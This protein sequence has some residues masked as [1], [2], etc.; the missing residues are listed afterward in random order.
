MKACLMIGAI[1]MAAIVTGSTVAG[2]LPDSGSDQSERF[3]PQLHFTPGKNW[4]NDPNGMI[5]YQGEYHLFFQYNPQGRR[6][7]HMSWGH[8]VSPDL[9]HWTELPLAIPEDD[10][11]MIFSGSVVVDK[12]NSSGFGAGGE[13][14]MVA[15]YT[16][17]AQPPG[18][19]QSQHLA[20]SLDHGRSWQKYAGNPILDLHLEDFRDPKVFWYE[21]KKTWIMLVS[22]AAARKIS[23]YQSSDLRNWTHIS[24]FGPAGATDGFW[25]C[26]DLFPLPV[27]GSPGKVKWVLKVDSQLSAIAPGGGGQYFVG[28]F[29]GTR[30][31]P[32][33][34]PI[35]DRGAGSPQ[36]IDF[37]SDYYASMTWSDSPDGRRIALGM[38]NNWSYGQDIPTGPWRGAMS[39]PRELTLRS[40]PDGDTVL[41][42]PLAALAQLRRREE[43]LP[44]T[45]LVPGRPVKLAESSVAEPL[46]IVCALEPDTSG[47]MGLTLTTGPAE[48][49][50]IRY[51][52]KTRRLT[53]DRSQSGLL[54]DNPA[55][56]KPLE[57]AIQ[58]QDGTVRLHIFIDRSSVELFV[59]DG[60]A[61]MT[62]QLFPAGKDRILHVYSASG[63]AK[64]A[65]YHM[66]RL[67]PAPEAAP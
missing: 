39:L 57:A 37:G 55:F 38:M 19:G 23:F 4:M 8:A 3:R 52:G 53:I 17:A 48:R 54:A 42:S 45:P 59:D 46:E 6:W 20:Y 15:I 9:V 67:R 26:P 40:G 43:S 64:L 58:P 12:T 51:D 66:W 65:S 29:D 11:V 47:E 50:V 41:Q 24:D 10:K 22:L 62:A 27:A 16:G 32:D 25:E 36:W 21:P 1:A 49:T 14:P 7:G 30:F 60:A 63:E 44:P 61:V 13:P 5:Y 18:K 56:A 34:G 33:P 35:S 31:T 2:E 28:T